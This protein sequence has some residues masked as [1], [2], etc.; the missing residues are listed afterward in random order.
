MNPIGAPSENRHGQPWHGDYLRMPPRRA[1]RTPRLSGTKSRRGARRGTPSQAA[2]FAYYDRRSGETTWEPPPTGYLRRDGLLVLATGEVCE[3]P[4]NVLGDAEKARNAAEAAASDLFGVLA[5]RAAEPLEA[6]QEFTKERL[7]LENGDIRTVRD[8][9]FDGVCGTLEEMA[10]E[11][12]YAGRLGKP[13]AK[14]P[15]ALLKSAEAA[16]EEAAA[17][18]KADLQARPVSVVSEA[19]EICMAGRGVARF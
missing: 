2:T 10:N 13:G 11:L 17:A 15:L 9:R 18:T 7:A 1:S 8:E 5:L 4:A 19:P 16:D 3:D 12:H 6:L 14:P